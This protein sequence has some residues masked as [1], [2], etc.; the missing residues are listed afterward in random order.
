MDNYLDDIERLINKSFVNI[1]VWDSEIRG[2][3]WVN[4]T[5]VTF[6]I[7]KKNFIIIGLNSINELLLEKII[8]HFYEKYFKL[9]IDETGHLNYINY[10]KQKIEQIIKWNHDGSFDWFSSMLSDTV[11]NI[12]WKWK[13]EKY[14]QHYFQE[15][16]LNLDI[17]KEKLKNI[18]NLR[19][20]LWH[21]SE[22]Y[23]QSN[24]KIKFEINDLEKYILILKEWFINLSHAYFYSMQDLLDI[25]YKVLNKFPN[26]NK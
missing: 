6:S 25:Q 19:N 4:P 15:N 5:D 13:I 26:I 20:K 21:N 17:F 2:I 24:D 18:N 11:W 14:I 23:F 16:K 9:L 8:F 7:T 1:E 3:K 10:E 12:I 22:F